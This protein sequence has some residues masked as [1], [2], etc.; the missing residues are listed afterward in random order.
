MGCRHSSSPP[1]SP[2]K[3][4]QNGGPIVLKSKISIHRA[5][6]IDY[7]TSNGIKS[8]SSSKLSTSTKKVNKFFYYRYN[9]NTKL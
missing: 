3:I 4:V 6:L 2:L 1:E 7:R 5:Q 9:S 8:V